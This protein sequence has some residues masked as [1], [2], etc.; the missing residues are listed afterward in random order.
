MMRVTI[1]AAMVLTAPASITIPAS[2]AA[3]QTETQAQGQG[4]CE[5]TPEK[6]AKRS[7]FGGVLSGVAGGILGGSDLGGMASLIPVGSIVADELLKLLDCKEQRQAANATN[8]AIRG[9]VGTEVKWQSESRQ[10]VSGVSKVTGQQELADGTNC[11]TVTDVV[12]IDGEETTVPKRMCRGR[13][14]S[15]YRKA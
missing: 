8:E 12:I 9:G 10:N 3:A 15:G 7:L 6:K 11:L 2:A 14:D 13:G 4:K 1:I 5:E